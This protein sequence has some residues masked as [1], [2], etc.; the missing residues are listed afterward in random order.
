MKK[1]YLFLTLFALWCFVS[2]LW[3]VFGVKGASDEPSMFSPQPMMLAIIEILIMLLGAFILGFG[4]AWMLRE[5]AFEDL[6]GSL[7]ES[8][9]TLQSKEREI[10]ETQSN[11]DV[12]ARRLQQAEEKILSL[13]E[14]NDNR[15]KDLEREAKKSAE[16]EKKLALHEAK[17]NALDGDASSARFRTRLLENELSEK[18]STIKKLAAE[19]EEL[20]RKPR[21]EHRDWSDHPFVRPVEIDEN[22]KDDLT[23][24]KGIGPAFQ[25]KLNSL[26][27]Y[28]F[29]QISEMS[30]EAVTRLAE[31]IEVFPDRI[32]RDNWIGQA[33][34]LYQRKLEG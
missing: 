22:D 12:T 24:I 8:R 13:L 30:G 2:A 25:K 31:A 5:P 17:V 33:T 1:G 23:E 16:L 32:H 20:N 21:I 6:Q 9:A 14:D 34:K 15:L 7:I 18:E 28:S 4:V 19:I 29:R 3:Y 11:G 10:T 26:D 27:I